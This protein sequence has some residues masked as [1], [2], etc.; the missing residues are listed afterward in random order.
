M[1][2][3]RAPGSALSPADRPDLFVIERIVFDTRSFALHQSQAVPFDPRM[4]MRV[5][6]GGGR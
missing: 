2:F 5:A 4:P 6:A 3:A 1:P